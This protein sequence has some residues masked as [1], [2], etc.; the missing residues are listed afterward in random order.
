MKRE[1][2]LTNYA[3]EIHDS[4][5]PLFNG[6]DFR[7]KHITVNIKGSEDI[8]VTTYPGAL[9][10]ILSNFI[11]NSLK[12]GFDN[13]DEGNII[14]TLAQTQKHVQII[15]AD[16]GKGMSESMLKQIYDPFVTSK[17]NEGGSGLGMHIVFNLVTQLFKGEIQCQ[18]K[19]N[20]GI[21]IIVK[22]PKSG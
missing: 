9:F 19:V 2:N 13:M 15:Y 20:E 5:K 22:F 7:D 17:R 11:E 21:E 8:V 1:I 18:S 10:Q 14:I 4:L 6:T 12:H 16:N 3:H